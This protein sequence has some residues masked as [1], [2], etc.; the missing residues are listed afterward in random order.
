MEEIIVHLTHKITNA[1]TYRVM[2][3]EEKLTQIAY[4]EYGFKPTEIILSKEQAI[5]LAKAILKKYDV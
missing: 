5:C 3:D 1:T 2:A 4:N